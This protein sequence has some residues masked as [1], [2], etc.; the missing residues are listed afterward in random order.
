MRTPGSVPDGCVRRGIEM[1]TGRRWGMARLFA[2]GLLWA[3]I[4]SVGFDRLLPL[5]L[6]FGLCLVLAVVAGRFPAWRPVADRIAWSLSYGALFAWA[7]LPAQEGVALGRGTVW[8]GAALLLALALVSQRGGDRPSVWGVLLVLLGVAVAY[9][10]GSPGSADPW[11][12]FFH[13]TLG[14][15]REAAEVAVFASRK[16][17]H[18]CGYGLFAW[19]ALREARA[20]GLSWR[21]AAI[22]ALLWTGA[23]AVFDETDQLFA[24]SR[25]ASVLDVAVDMLGAAAFVLP[26]G[27]RRD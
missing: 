27:R 2:A 14:L 22:A 8:A 5:W 10:S 20:Q 13:E 11:Y 15:S 1:D 18:F 19:V 7:W 24:G 25:N 16:G 3:P 9:F 17:L 12:R 4:V 26:A 21:S 23:H 6:P